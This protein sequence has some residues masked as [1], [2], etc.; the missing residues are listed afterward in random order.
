M[1]Y[2][3]NITKK[4]KLFV[5]NKIQFIRDNTNAKQLFYVAIKS[6]IT[7][8]SSGGLK[9]VK[10]H[11][12]KRWL[13]GPL[14]SYGNQNQEQPRQDTIEVD[15]SGNE[16][17]ITV[18]TN[19]VTI[20]TDTLTWETRISSWLKL[21]EIRC[22]GFWVICDSSTVKSVTFKCVICCK[23]RGRIGEQIMADLPI[24]RL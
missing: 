15:E 14:S 12:T 21:N 19:L 16:V 3:K 1:N 11:K 22:N 4:F 2:I 20:R 18:T 13:E 7:D 17:R 10:C 23:L 5:A 24:D 8:D 9:D 6:S